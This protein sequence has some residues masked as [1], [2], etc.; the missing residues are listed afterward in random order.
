MA[1][2][3]ARLVIPSASSSDVGGN[4]ESGESG[5][6]YSQCITLCIAQKVTSK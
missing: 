5:K 6:Y 4:S 1:Q 3:C 2:A